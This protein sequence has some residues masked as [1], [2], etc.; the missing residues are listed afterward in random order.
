MRFYRYVNSRFAVALLLAGNAGCNSEMTDSLGVPIAM[1][2]DRIAASGIGTCIIQSSETV[3]WGYGGPRRVTPGDG[4]LRFV[5]LRGG[6]G[7]FCGL[8]AD[9]TA[10]C[11]GYNTYGELGD[12]TTTNRDL[13]TRVVTTQKF[14]A[15]SASGGTTCAVNGGGVAFCWGRSDF[16][17]LGNGMDTNNPPVLLPAP[18]ATPV[19][20][21]TVYGIGSNCGLTGAG[22]AYCWGH[23]PGSYDLSIY[24]APGNCTTAYYEWYQGRQCLVP[25][26][27]ATDLRFASLAGSGCGLTAAGDAYCWGD[28]YNGTF[29][30]GRTGVYS[31]TPV[32]VGGGIRFAQLTGGGTYA[33][34]IDLTGTAYCWGNNFV[35][36]LGIGEHGF[37]AHYLVAVPTPVS[38][39][40]KFIAIAS[41]GA[42]TCGLTSTSQVLCWGTNDYGELGPGLAASLSDVPVLVQLPPL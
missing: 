23:V 35:G 30:D 42:H 22:R 1:Q 40:A 21:H 3:C 12:G 19:R 17:N 25:T 24:I 37:G 31:V 8:T 18:V 39:S 26:P 20:F 10:Y 9:S 11:W 28:G 34:G 33:C 14:I 32:R 6:G 15:I 41:G 36:E 7:N 13:P 27:I 2:S 16:G 38:T 29:G 4:S 5:A